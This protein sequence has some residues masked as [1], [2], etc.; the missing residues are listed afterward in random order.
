MSNSVSSVSIGVFTIGKSKVKN[1]GGRE[2]I[3]V[4]FGEVNCTVGSTVDIVS[5][6]SLIL[7]YLNFESIYLVLFYSRV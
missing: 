4:D 3:D 7:L 5:E 1:N 2:I 6:V